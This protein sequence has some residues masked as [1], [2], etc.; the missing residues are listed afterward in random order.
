MDLLT[1]MC[2]Y[3][4][5]KT[6]FYRRIN[7][8]KRR[9]RQRSRENISVF[10][11]LAVVAVSVILFIVI[12]L[13]D[14]GETPPDI[15]GTAETLSGDVTGSADLGEIG[16][17]NV[18]KVSSASEFNSLISEGKLSSFYG[19]HGALPTVI[20]SDGAVFDADVNISCG[21]EIIFA[22]KATWKNGAVL[23]VKTKDICDIS[24]TTDE[25]LDRFSF[26][27]P[28]ASLTWS[29]GN[30]PFMYE[31]ARKMNVST[32]NGS[33][34]TDG[35]DKLGGDG[36]AVITDITLYKDKTKSDPVEA[37]V[38]VNGNVITLSY[39]WNY[40]G[41][42]IGNAYIDVIST[43]KCT[44]DLSSPVDL[45]T[46][47][48]VTVADES[49]KTRTYR[50]TSKRQSYGIPTVEINTSTGK[51]IDTREDYIV[52]EMI[53][54]GESYP[55]E[56][57]GRGNASW[58]TFPKKAY[59]I[60]LDEK[61]KLLGMPANRDW[62]L[63]SNY[64]DPSLIRNNIASDMAKCLDGL[65]FTPTHVSVDLYVNGE[66]LGVYGF[67]EKIEDA[68]S[69][70]DLGDPITDTN[71]NIT[72][73]GFL[74]ELGW[75]YYSENVY[76]KDYF[77]LD[78]MIRIYIKEPTVEAKNDATFKYIYDYVRA[79]EKA[80][81]SGEGWQDY[82][83]TDSWV[84]WFIIN[85]LCNNT[86]SSF[87]RSFFMYKTADGK[88]SAGPIWDYD[89]SFGNFTGDLPAY[90]RGWVTVDSTF[91]YAYRNWMYFLLRDEE[92]VSLVKARWAEVGEELYK[93]ALAS[94]DE[95]AEELQKAA[96]NNFTRWNKVL[97]HKVGLSRASA[98]FD[99]WDGQIDYIRD[100]IETRYNFMNEK[101]TGDGGIL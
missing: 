23:T 13:R 94:I 47:S 90:D 2:Y 63:V 60:K 34:V 88:L 99:T 92:F 37:S 24:L 65:D 56:I 42:N 89:M 6:S 100:F 85:E 78:Y 28:N 97:G 69:R 79:A 98:K 101:L 55:I 43:G 14:S 21:V 87:H 44:L 7:V 31:I 29:G 40:N 10:T 48:L 38:T 86:E 59:R 3:Y 82:L 45:S 80:V 22:G 84:D 52:S 18:F 91:T 35:G 71:G 61:A 74:C 20:V 1:Y 72:D 53:I 19:E 27:A 36:D 11:V 49:G 67:A 70:V 51:D 5:I 9:R 57:R 32:F 16:Y 58:T 33:P 77:D 4:K 62:V 46:P 30:V 81:V 50:I 39:P 76:K 12:A 75:D 25:T 26:D 66:Y 73:F 83:D 8:K 64:A 93:T 41:K 68:K 95:N 15:P 96:D 54:D 17:G